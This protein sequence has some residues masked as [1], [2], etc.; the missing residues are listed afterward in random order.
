MRSQFDEVAK[1]LARG[2]SRRRVLGGIISG[3]VGVV[4]ASLLPGSRSETVE[5]GAAPAAD[6]SVRQASGA[7]LPSPGVRLNQAPVRLNQ[8]PGKLNRSAM[9][10]HQVPARINQTRQPASFNQARVRSRTTAQGARAQSSSPA[11]NQAQFNQA[12]FNQLRQQWLTHGPPPFNSV[13]PQFNQS[14]LRL[15]QRGYPGWNQGH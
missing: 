13:H 11:L 3:L 2:T 9:Q 6:S 5:A 12:R 8:G 15:N 14:P 1:A 4:A 10:S 7:N